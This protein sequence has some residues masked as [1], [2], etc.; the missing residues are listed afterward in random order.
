MA[1]IQIIQTREGIGQAGELMDVSPERAA[2]W[3]ANG[4]AVLV[5]DEKKARAIAKAEAAKA[6]AAAA[7]EKAKA[8]EAAEAAEEAPA[9]EGK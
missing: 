7:V 6:K 8:A 4:I 9:A 5:D 1:Q 3:A 2:R